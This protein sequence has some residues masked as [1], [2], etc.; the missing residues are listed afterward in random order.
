MRTRDN[1]GQ[2]VVY[3]GLSGI[4]DRTVRRTVRRMQFFDLDAICV[5]IVNTPSVEVA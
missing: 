3:A 4:D 2:A 5:S 1:A